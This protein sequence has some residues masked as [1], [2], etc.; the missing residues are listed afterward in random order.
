MWYTVITHVL[1]KHREWKVETTILDKSTLSCRLPCFGTDN[2]HSG[3]RRFCEIHI[4]QNYNFHW[5]SFMKITL[6]QNYTFHWH[7]FMKI[8][9][10]NWK[11]INSIQIETELI[12]MIPKYTWRR[13]YGWKYLI[14]SGKPSWNWRKT[15]AIAAS[16]LTPI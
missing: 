4:F 1:T 2:S 6:F 15:C 5:H 10:K 3:I 13:I 12:P 16:K 7:S 14:Y 9:I 11:V 8:F